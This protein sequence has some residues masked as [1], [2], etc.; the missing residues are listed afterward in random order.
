M[1][2]QQPKPDPHAPKTSWWLDVES[3]DAF[4][5]R[6]AEEAVRMKLK[7]PFGGGMLLAGWG[8]PK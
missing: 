2:R 6:A 7:K 1:T 4:D 5:Q 8:N 3:R